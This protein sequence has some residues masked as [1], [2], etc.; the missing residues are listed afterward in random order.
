MRAL[1]TG[2]D[3]QLRQ[4]LAAIRPDRDCEVIALSRK[5][6]DIT[7]P[8]SVGQAVERH[9]PEAVVNA[10]AYTNVDDCE[11][12]VEAAYVVNTLG[13][14]NLTRLCEQ[15]GCELV[16]VSTNYVFDGHS[17]R[18]YE[19]FDLPNPTNV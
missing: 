16:H 3:G 10:A 1:V 7:D 15:Q 14:R 2:A 8:G 5:A 9:S 13:P 17:E 12:E 19:T 11:T 4:E 18:P 6:L